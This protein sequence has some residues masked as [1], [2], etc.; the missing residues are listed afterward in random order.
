[1]QDY[2]SCKQPYY[3][4]TTDNHIISVKSLEK[5]KSLNITQNN[6]TYF[7]SFFKNSEE[8]GIGVSICEINNNGD[9]TPLSDV[10]QSIAYE[11]NKLTITGHYGSKKSSK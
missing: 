1:M 2:T 5:V 8:C 4:S 3:T 11:N 9:V 7:L 10:S 6:R